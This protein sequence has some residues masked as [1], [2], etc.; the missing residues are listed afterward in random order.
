M[1][2]GLTPKYYTFRRKESNVSRRLCIPNGSNIMSVVFHFSLT[3]HT[4]NCMIRLLHKV[5]DRFSWLL[6]LTVGHSVLK[7][8]FYLQVTCLSRQTNASSEAECLLQTCNF[9]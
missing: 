5:K 3:A 2:T 9:E 4:I 8:N 7:N 6:Y 1:S